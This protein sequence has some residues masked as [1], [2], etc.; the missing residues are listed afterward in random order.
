MGSSFYLSLGV[1]VLGLGIQFLG[2]KSSR[3]SESLCRLLF[4]GSA[5]FVLLYYIILTTFQ[6][7]VWKNGGEPF[8]YFLPPYESIFYLLN[9][10]FIRFLL[11][12]LISFAAALLL[13]YF[14]RRYDRKMGFRFF[15]KEEP[16]FGAVSIFLLG[17]PAWCW[18]WVY[19]VAGVLLLSVVISLI[20]GHISRKEERFS[21]YHVW[22]PTAILVIIIQVLVL[23][24]PSPVF[25]F[26]H[27][28]ITSKGWVSNRQK[29][30]PDLAWKWS[31]VAEVSLK[32]KYFS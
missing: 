14:V 8:V 31:W 15:E 6:Y 3:K 11:Y 23:W 7:F 30:L 32:E 12:Y 9:Y 26:K 19:Y 17:N 20:R 25:V 5:G 2:S 16:Y 10:H 22:F 13:L 27:N 29:F 21:L 18:S 4:F 28:L 1:I 24:L